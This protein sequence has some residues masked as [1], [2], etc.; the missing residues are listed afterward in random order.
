[1]PLAATIPDIAAI[2]STIIVGRNSA[3]LYHVERTRVNA[4][5]LSRSPIMATAIGIISAISGFIGAVVTLLTYLG[6]K[7]KIGRLS[8]RISRAGFKRAAQS[9]AL[10][11]SVGLVIF[12]IGTGSF[13]VYQ[14]GGETTT[15]TIPSPTVKITSLGPGQR[16]PIEVS[17]VRGT[18]MGLRPGQEIWIVVV[19][20]AR[21]YP[22]DGPVVVAP[23]GNWVSPPVFFGIDRDAGRTFYVLAVLANSPAGKVFDHYIEVGN[24]TTNFPGISRLPTGASE[25]YRVVVIRR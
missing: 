13:A 12:G 16:V 3:R 5:V 24:R 8:I 20:A 15:T 17:E 18:S 11:V 25:Y 9:L 22:Q 19:S 23:N 1:M 10:G 7:I 14:L 21:Y 6:V 2:P 4:A